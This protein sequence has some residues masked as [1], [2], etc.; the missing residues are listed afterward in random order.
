[1]LKLFFV[2]HLSFA[3]VPFQTNTRGRISTEF[4]SVNQV[5]SPRVVR[6]AY[7]ASEGL[8]LPWMPAA[9]PQ[10]IATELRQYHG[11]PFV[12]FTGQL[13]TYLM[14]PS[15]MFGEKITKLFDEYKITGPNRLPTVGIHVRRTD[16]VS[17]EHILI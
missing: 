7:I 8:H 15:R 9:I 4:T 5:D 13:L 10:D 12:W 17:S 16:K 6:C 11:A 3:F 1:M 14:R 2:F